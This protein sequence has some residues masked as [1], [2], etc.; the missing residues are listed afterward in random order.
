ML[1]NQFDR[2]FYVLEHKAV[3][4]HS[5]VVKKRGKTTMKLRQEIVKHLLFLQH[6]LVLKTLEFI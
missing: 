6:P 4:V 2:H 1:H 5:R 3:L